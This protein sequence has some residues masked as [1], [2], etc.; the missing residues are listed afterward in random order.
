[1]DKESKFQCVIQKKR[2]VWLEDRVN[3]FTGQSN[4]KA[5]TISLF[6]PHSL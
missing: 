3:C 1:M 6:I 5:N 4:K 2:E